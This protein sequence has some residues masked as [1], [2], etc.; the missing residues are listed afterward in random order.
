MKNGR[1]LS[2]SVRQ[3]F[4]LNS[5]DIRFRRPLFRHFSVRTHS[6]GV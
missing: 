5:Y 4:G 6:R 3:L 1:L 2:I